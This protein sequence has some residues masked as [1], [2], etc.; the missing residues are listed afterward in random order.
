MVMDMKFQESSQKQK[1]VPKVLNQ[2]K[3]YLEGQKK[4][5]ETLDKF[6]KNTVQANRAISSFELPL[7]KVA[8]WKD[9]QYS[10]GAAAA[11]NAFA[12]AHK[13][14]FRVSIKVDTGQMHMGEHNSIVHFERKN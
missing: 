6:Y 13:D 2:D 4:T 8:F 9:N 1:T 12:N 3:Q 5:V 14:E 10:N 11:V 7:E